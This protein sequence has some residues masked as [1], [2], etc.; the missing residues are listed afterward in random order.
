MIYI[1][2][3]VKI[4]KYFMYY[5]RKKAEV[6]SINAADEEM[7]YILVKRGERK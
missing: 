2:K 1:L 3:M 5:V 6:K 7:K 4:I